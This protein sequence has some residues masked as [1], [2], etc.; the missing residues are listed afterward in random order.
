MIRKLWLSCLL[1]VLGIMLL[2]VAVSAQVV[3]T[4]DTVDTADE[5][6]GPT[7]LPVTQPVSVMT[8]FTLTVLIPGDDGPMTVEVPIMLQLSMSITLGSDLTPTV[9][10]TP[11]ID[12]VGLDDEADE[13]TE[14]EADAADATTEDVVESVPVATPAVSPVATTP[15]ATATPLPT[16]AATPDTLPTSTP[17]GAAEETEEA[18]APADT[19]VPDEGAE[20]TGDAA[21][22]E[23]ADETADETTGEGEPVTIAPV[24]PDPRSVISS[25]G[26]NQVLSGEVTVTG[27]AVHENFQ[28]YKIEYAEGADPDNTGEYAFLTDGRI[29]VS[30]GALATFDST[31]FANGTYTLRLSVV[32]NT[33]NFPPPCAVTVVIEN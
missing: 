3:D 28:Y 10:T 22:D 23:A 16:V 25:P 24:C 30:D 15:V 4:A 32:D 14:D 6:D 21:T 7:V 8:P 33:G 18:A 27:T 13:A 12:I 17:V 19:P 26:V 20:D 11:T 31:E 5:L 9:A 1:A 29:Q 2:A